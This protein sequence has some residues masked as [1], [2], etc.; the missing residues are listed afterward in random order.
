MKI[1]SFNPDQEGYIRAHKVIRTLGFGIED[2]KV[3]MWA[4]T[5]PLGNQGQSINFLVKKTGDSVTG[6]DVRSYV[7][8]M[9]DKDDNNYHIFA[10]ASQILQ[11]G[12]QQ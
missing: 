11:P 12:L 8:T 4:V 3:T 1:T 7:T 6:E 10:E 9:R 2:G 5:D